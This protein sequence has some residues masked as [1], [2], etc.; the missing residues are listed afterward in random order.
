MPRKKISILVPTYN[1]AE[2]VTDLF[3][4]I[5]AEFEASLPH[6]DYEVLFI[7]NASA[8]GTREKLAALAAADTRV[9]VILNT[10]NFGQ[11]N[12]PF[13]GICATS[14]DCTIPLC[15]D[16]QDPVELI[17]ALVAKW[18]AG[19]RVVVAI[20]TESLENPLLRFLRTCY[21]KAIRRLSPVPLIEHFTGFGLYDRSFVDV[22]RDLEDPTPFLRGIVAELGSAVT[23]LPYRQAKRRRGKSHNSL[24]TLYDA[25]MLSF[26]TYTKTPLRFF[27]L[28]GVF[29]SAGGA[30]AAVI[31]ALLQVTLQL[32]FGLW[33]LLPPMAFFAGL[34]LLSAGMLGE[35]ILLLR[36]KLLKRPL[37]IEEK[38]LNF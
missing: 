35:Y 31:L 13:Y 15:A 8:D 32:S 7:D 34:Q 16:F 27:S 29:F 1:E 38:R 12:S 10:R 30:L 17:P 21:Y 28:A 9:R 25:A 5:R 3:A 23:T 36:G 18:E 4:A 19:A 14:G 22:L 37:V 11:F 6:Y 20:K 26:T 2:N 24:A 33:W